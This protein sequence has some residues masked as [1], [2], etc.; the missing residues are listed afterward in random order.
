MLR[1]IY[2][3]HQ[4]IMMVVGKLHFMIYIMKKMKKVLIIIKIIFIPNYKYKYIFIYIQKLNAQCFFF[5]FYVF[6]N[7]THLIL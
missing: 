7:E 2:L 3:L 4:N 1:I 5:F 6:Q